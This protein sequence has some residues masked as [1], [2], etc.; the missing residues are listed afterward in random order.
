MKD[1][2]L[3]GLLQNAAILLALSYVYEF[4]WNKN[5]EPK[6]NLYKVLTGFIIALIG[7]VLM[8]TPWILVPGLVFDTRSV[9]LS[10]SGLFF[11]KLPTT[12]AMILLSLFRLNQGGGG[13]WMGLAVIISSGTIGLLWSRFRP[14]RQSKHYQLELILM[15]VLVHI[16]MLSCT[17]LLPEGQRLNTFKTIALPVLGIYPAATLLLGTLIFRQFKNWQNRNA[18]I[19]LMESER[20]FSELLKNTFLFSAIIDTEGKIVY[21]N[22]ALLEASGFKIEEISEKNFLDTFVSEESKEELGKQFIRALQGDQ[23]ALNIESELI[24]KDGSKIVASFNCTVLRDADGKIEGIAGIGENITKRKRTESE[25]IKAK[26]I[27]EESDQLKSIFLANM[28]HE[29]RTPM[30]SIMGFSE[31]LGEKWV[32]EESR[33]QYIDIIKNSSDRLLQ[34][35]NDII[36]ISKIE[37]KQLS[38]NLSECGLHDLLITSTESFRKSGLLLKKP[39]IELHFE[40]PAEYAKIKFITDC[41]RVQQVLDNLISNAIKY[42]IR[43]RI[44]VGCT[45][46]TEKNNEFIEIYVKD[47]GIGISKEMADIIFERFRQ[48]EESKFHEGAGLGL[49]IS[50]GIIELLGG[51]IWLTSQ[52]GSG[53]TFYFMIPYI[54][55]EKDIDQVF[56]D[57]LTVPQINGKSIIIAEDDYNSY[58][59]LDLMLRKYNAEILHAEN[60]EVLMQ[61]IQNKMPDLILLDINMPLMS[62]FEVLNKMRESGLKTKIIAQTAYAMSGEKEKC[63]SSGC[64]GYISKPINKADLFRVINEVLSV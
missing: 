30:N 28:S 19:K 10:V 17:M 33:L 25:M 35:I 16:V 5:G 1:S 13:V 60:G 63:I 57:V 42:S 9:V 56:H 47:T 36:D 41:V 43:G 14:L 55:A 46:K 11:G 53:T 39:E 64:N 29:I 7:L 49:S 44:D 62:G 15:G 40:F 26:V 23:S 58:R 2:I 32:S 3:V 24:I 54:L 50:K 20:R 12:I 22:N 31:L 51:K 38:I 4:W 18:T 27:A 59:Y 48:V 61:M 8:L 34:L 52:V 45:I 21:C 37:A 6:N